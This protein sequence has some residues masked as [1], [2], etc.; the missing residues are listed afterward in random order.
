[1]PENEVL[2]SLEVKGTLATMKTAFLL[3]L[4]LEA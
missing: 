2:N 3:T 1:M 4:I